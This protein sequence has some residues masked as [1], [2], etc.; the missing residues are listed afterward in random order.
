MICR[1]V[2]SPLST[3]NRIYCV[4]I[5]SSPTKLLKCSTSKSSLTMRLFS[6]NAPQSVVVM[7][8]YQIINTPPGL[9]QRV[10]CTEM[11]QRHPCPGHQFASGFLVGIAHYLHVLGDLGVPAVLQTSLTGN[12]ESGSYLC[13]D[14]D[15][16]VD[17]LPII[18]P[19]KK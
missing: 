12:N 19:S 4:N 10:R 13:S 8:E 3:R 15:S 1:E 18:D 11:P 7:V 6:V 9:H 17:P 2:H 16:Y 14:L 5:L